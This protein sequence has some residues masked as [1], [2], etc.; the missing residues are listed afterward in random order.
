MSG[1]SYV[2]EKDTNRW[3]EFFDVGNRSLSKEDIAT[4]I[5]TFQDFIKEKSSDC[6][7]SIRMDSGGHFL[8]VIGDRG[9]YGFDFYK[10]INDNFRGS[11][12]INCANALYMFPRN[13]SRGVFQGHDYEDATD[14]VDDV[15]TGYMD[16]EEVANITGKHQYVLRYLRTNITIPISSGEVIIGRSTREATFVIKGNTNVSRR[17]C[18]IFLRGKLYIIDHKS[19]N[20]TYINNLQINPEVEKELRVGDKIMV[21]DEEFVVE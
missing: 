3:R 21:A 1:I 17:H 10:Y 2:H 18:T 5:E 20:G 4:L 11:E 15:S 16:E 7:R 13:L 9:D 8:F 12:R 14:N 6:I 19:L